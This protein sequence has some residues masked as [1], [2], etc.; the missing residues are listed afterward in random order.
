MVVINPAAQ[1]ILDA[2][3]QP[4][5]LDPSR[6]PV[7][8]PAEVIEHTLRQLAELELL[9][10]HGITQEPVR[11]QSRTLT[12]W[13]HVTNA[14]N[15]R[16][17]YCYVNKTE[18]E[19][20]EETGLAAVAAVF[21]SA[22]QHGFSAVK[23]KYAG[24]ESTLN[25][26]LVQKLHQHALAQV[27]QTGLALRE[28]VQSNGVGLS[29]LMI[30]GMR[31]MGMRLMISLDGVGEAHDAQRPFANGKG[32]FGHVA[33]GIDRAIALGL[34]PH[35]SIT[36]TGQSAGGLREAVRF[37]LVRELRFNLNFYRDHECSSTRAQ[38]QNENTQLIAGV[39]DAFEEIVQN[40][41][42][43]RVIDGLIDHST[44]DQPHEHACGAGHNYMV[45]DHNGGVTRC[46][47]EIERTITD[48]L[49]SDPL[50]AVR[51]D[52]NGFQNV[53]VSQKEGCREC[54][55][56]HWCAGGCSLLTFKATGRTDIQ[57]PYCEVYK[58]L[59]PAALRL[60]GLRLLKWVEP[61]S[62]A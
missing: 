49:A 33:R 2:F 14:C 30:E 60:E 11:S 48:V 21:R 50:Q 3:L 28:V 6:V 41:P 58:A 40:L 29:R 34:K 32:S 23:L 52:K 9:T 5:T 22:R 35:L 55:W 61:M 8:L 4:G 31:E 37:A 57:S 7:D 1:A 54:E 39:L 26:G 36:V 53:A 13:L 18:D 19:M 27:Q 51:A 46:Q 10:P 42:A 47:M 20:S 24:G 43:E 15:L 25:F 56:Q 45:I 59:Y 62:C 12:A 44:F 17:H 38:M 16:C